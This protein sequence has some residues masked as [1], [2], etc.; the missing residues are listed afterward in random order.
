M[1]LKLENVRAAFVQVH[2]AK[3]VNGE[4][5]PAFSI[6]L[7]I[8]KDSPQIKR[9]NAG[10]DSVAKEKWAD[11]APAMLKNLRAGDKTCMHDGDLKENYEGFADH[12]FISAR[13]KTR[14]LVLDRDKT[15]L[16]LEDGKPYSGCYVNAMLD[17]WAQDNKYGK[18]VN[19]SLKGIQ[20]V[21][22]GD[23]FSASAPASPDAFD[24]LS[25]GSEA[26]DIA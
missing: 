13:T 12:F 21:K 25:D 5:E 26:D 16:T 22:D 9:I 4:G 10:I 20:F 17:L 1:E 2:E 11:K 19:A 8:P 15:P 24:D 3:Q 18:R 14:P 6:S 7:L 23:A